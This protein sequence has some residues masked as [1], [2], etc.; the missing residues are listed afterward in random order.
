MRNPRSGVAVLFLGVSALVL[1]AIAMYGTYEDKQRGKY[2]V[3]I[4][5][6]AVVYG[7]HS[8][9]TM[10]SVAIPMHRASVPMVS[11]SAIHEYAYYGH[12]SMPTTAPTG[13]GLYTTS[14]AKVHTIGSGGGNGGG[15]MISG[16]SSSS[17]RGVSHSGGSI[18][19]PSLP[20]L[21]INTSSLATQTYAAEATTPRAIGPRKIPGYDG[22]EDGEAGQ[23]PD[24]KEWWIWDDEEEEWV[25]PSNGDSYTDEFGNVYEYQGTYPD[26]SWVWISGP[27]DPGVPVGAT[28]WL[29]MLALAAAYTT[30]RVI[31]HRKLQNNE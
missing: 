21:A 22:T 20:S 14:S 5:P 1:W 30:R 4:K 24:T 13:R 19:M 27:G 12:A 15:G 31:K 10:P 3:S 23:D 2:E 18:S 16:G 28:P 6:G 11:S 26:G 25:R 9:A 7:T 29:M 8:T 17:S